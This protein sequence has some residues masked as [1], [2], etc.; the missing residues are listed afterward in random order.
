MAYCDW[1]QQEF[2]IA[3]A[4]SGDGAMMEAYASGDPYLMFAKQ[5]GAVPAD[6]TKQSHPRE[7]GQFKVCALAVQYGMGARS[8]SRA[9]G[10]PE[11]VGRELRHLYQQ[12]YPR[13]WAWSEAAVNHAML[14]GWLQTVFGWRIQVGPDCNPRSLAN[15]PM[16]ANGADMLRLACCLAT[17]RGIAVCAPVHDALLVEGPAEIIET[18]VAATQAAMA[19]A[20]RI[21]LNG[22]E[23]RSDA[24]IIRWPER[25]MDERGA[26]MW[27]TIMG[28]L[29]ELNRDTPQTD[30]SHF[31][32]FIRCPLETVRRGYSIGLA[33]QQIT[34]YVRT[35]D[36][37]PERFG[38]PMIR[39]SHPAPAKPKADEEERSDGAITARYRVRCQICGEWIH[40]K[41]EA[42]HHSRKIKWRW[43]HARC[44]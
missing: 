39:N 15:F 42:R 17:E 24:K 29:A 11:V 22:F 32:P 36:N 16:Q 8:L 20:A 10:Q 38:V 34:P 21:T 1:S 18:V 41:E 3:A 2:G 44:R 31:D 12:T 6:A 33:L 27:N 13:Y 19:E 40:R 30:V 28:I 37:L 26:K 7:R 25:Y 14:C 9:I 35:G 43:C 23:L 5:A 4:L